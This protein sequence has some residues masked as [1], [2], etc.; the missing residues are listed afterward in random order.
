[1]TNLEMM[2]NAATNTMVEGKE[3]MFMNPPYGVN[4]AINAMAELAVEIMVPQMSKNTYSIG[5]DMY[6]LFN[7]ATMESGMRYDLVNEELIEYPVHFINFMADEE[8]L[9]INISNILDKLAEIKKE[10]GDKRVTL[11]I[12]GVT[13]VL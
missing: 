2:K 4:T 3:G 6:E 11:M 10:V 12:D 7:D 9:Y 8:V 13:Y 5:A 1:M